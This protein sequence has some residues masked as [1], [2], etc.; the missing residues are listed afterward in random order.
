M[1]TW[2]DEYDRRCRR[3]LGVED[4]ILAVY[5]DTDWGGGGCETCGY[6]GEGSVTI[7]VETE[8]GRFISRDFDDVGDMIRALDEVSL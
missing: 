7:R 1:S 3:L 5:V 4:D 2:K 8:T 6:G